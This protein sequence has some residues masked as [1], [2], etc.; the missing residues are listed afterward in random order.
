[1]ADTDLDDPHGG[2]DRDRE[3]EEGAVRG[4]QWLAVIILLALAGAAIYCVTDG[5]RALYVTEIYINPIPEQICAPG[6]SVSTRVS[7][8]YTTTY[9][10]A[11][12][13]SWIRF[14][15]SGLPAGVSCSV[16]P[17]K[18]DVTRSTGTWT[19]WTDLKLNVGSGVAPGSYALTFWAEEVGE[20]DQPGEWAYRSFVLVVTTARQ[21]TIEG[22]VYDSKY[23]TPLSNVEVYADGVLKLTTA[24][25]G[26]YSVSFGDQNTRKM[27]FK[28]DGY[29][30]QTLYITPGTT[31]DVY[32][33]PVAASYFDIGGYVKDADTKE[34]IQS[35]LVELLG[36]DVHTFTS[37]EGRWVLTDVQEGLRTIRFS[38]AGYQ[39]RDVTLTVTWNKLDYEHFLVPT[40][41]PTEPWWGRLLEGLKTPMGMVALIV[42][43]NA[44][45]AVAVVAKGG[46]K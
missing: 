29:V 23:K 37:S 41:P 27:E 26:R 9:V 14:S 44:L 4:D 39:T 5:F 16:D 45:I 42:A 10:A 6:A 30:A 11:E 17:T 35:V 18:I 28:K 24:G 22:T 40:A 1:V 2:I 19:W 21:Y 3:E 13:L 8:T 25:D 36:T 32:L 7:G 43:I 20:S 34:P 46:K 15:V 38:K 33:D 31:R 12:P